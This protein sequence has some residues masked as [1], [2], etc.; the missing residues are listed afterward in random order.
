VRPPGFWNGQRAESGEAPGAD[1][2]RL[3]R[4]LAAM[5]LTAVGLFCALVG[6]GTWLV[7]GT[8][9]ALLPW[10][11]LWLPALLS[12]SVVCLWQARRFVG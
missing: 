7:S 5:A 8:I 1:R 9:P 6:L 3:A 11:A 12:S 10:P 4:G 2:R